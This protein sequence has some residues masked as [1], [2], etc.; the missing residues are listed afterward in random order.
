MEWSKILNINYSKV[1]SRISVMNWSALEAL[2]LVERKNQWLHKNKL[3]WLKIWDSE[4]V[5]KEKNG[6]Y[7]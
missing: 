7:I 5:W 3:L 4:I 2:E 6:I 1:T